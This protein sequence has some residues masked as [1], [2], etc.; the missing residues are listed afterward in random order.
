MLLLK[1]TA[2]LFVAS[3]MLIPIEANAGNFFTDSQWQTVTDSRWFSGA[4]PMVTML[5]TDFYDNLCTRKFTKH[6]WKPKNGDSYVEDNWSYADECGSANHGVQRFFLRGLIGERGNRVET[7]QIRA[8]TLPIYLSDVFAIKYS[9]VSDRDKTTVNE[10][11]VCNYKSE[12]RASS[13]VTGAV[14]GMVRIYDCTKAIE[15]NIGTGPYSTTLRM[16]YFADYGMF[17]KLSYP[18]FPGGEA[19]KLMSLSGTAAKRH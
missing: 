17:Y 16:G 19:Y 13:V 7:I 5:T 14:S 2:L 12:R 8:K 9:T 18:R 6:T 10:T 1:K 3:V 15:Q 4:P 11:R